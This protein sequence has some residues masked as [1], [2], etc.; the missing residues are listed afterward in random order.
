MAV[1]E[2]S[3]TFLGLRLCMLAAVAVVG[4][5]A[6]QLYRHRRALLKGGHPFSSDVRPHP[7]GENP[8]EGGKEGA[9]AGDSKR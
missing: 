3:P 2:K 9:D 8:P 6:Y 4:Y 7:G 1:P 5:V